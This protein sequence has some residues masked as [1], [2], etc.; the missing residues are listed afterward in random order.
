[1]PFKDL[2]SDFNLHPYIKGCCNANSGEIPA[3]MCC[4]AKTLKLVYGGRQCMSPLSG[5]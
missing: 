1:M 4:D 3:D 2:V 5:W